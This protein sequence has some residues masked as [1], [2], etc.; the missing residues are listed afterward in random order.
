MKVNHLLLLNVFFLASVSFLSC[1]KDPVPVNEE[2]LITTLTYKLTSSDGQTVTLKFADKDGAG[3]QNPEI[4]SSGPLKKGQVYQGELQLLD[5]TAN[6][7]DNITAEIISEA[8][9]HQF[10]FETSSELNQKITFAYADNDANGNP[11][12]IKTL[13]NC[14]SSGTGTVTITLRHEPDKGAAGVRDGKIT[15]AGGETDI[16]VTFNVEIRD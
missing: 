7:P 10:F 8:A 9:A 15:N 14:I 2:E 3:G 12:G 11:L 1:G 5:E 16:Q 6:P 13:V 4:T